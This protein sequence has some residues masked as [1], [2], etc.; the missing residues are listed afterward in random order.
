MESQIE[1]AKRELAAIDP[2]DLGPT[3]AERA[4]TY[5]DNR[6]ILVDSGRRRWLKRRKKDEYIDFQDHHRD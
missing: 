5:Q 6:E 2:Y 3:K 4:K 1:E